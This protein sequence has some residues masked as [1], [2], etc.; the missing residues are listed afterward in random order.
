M[1]WQNLRCLFDTYARLQELSLP[2]VEREALPMLQNL[3][4]ADSR[5][6]AARTRRIAP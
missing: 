1:I 5:S 2:A 3:S 4:E 6:R